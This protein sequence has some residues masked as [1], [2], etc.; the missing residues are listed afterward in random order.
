M[1]RNGAT[2]FAFLIF[3]L[4]FLSINCGGKSK[5]DKYVIVPTGTGTRTDT[6]TDTDSG[7]DTGTGT[8][9]DTNLY[10]I[11]AYIDFAN[12]NYWKFR[13]QDRDIIT[14]YQAGELT[15]FATY[16]AWPVMAGNE[17]AKL[18]CDYYSMENGS[19]VHIGQEG[20]SSTIEYQPPLRYG[21]A[22]MSAGAEWYDGGVYHYDNGSDYSY[23]SD[24]TFLGT[25]NAEFD[26][27]ALIPDCIIIE[28]EIHVALPSP[29][30]EKRTYYWAPGG[31]MVMKTTRIGLSDI[32]P[33][34]V[35]SNA[36]DP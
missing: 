5:S 19:L 30:D 13:D 36:L 16:S 31:G 4:I 29:V 15:A 3:S 33:K 1:G 21:L 7:T 32:T 17:T 10:D 14:D 12:G 20:T 34:L 11:A 8:G 23:T 28:Q 6:N 2:V 27:G 26:N 25:G 35:E 22:S 18:Y 9:T 24:W